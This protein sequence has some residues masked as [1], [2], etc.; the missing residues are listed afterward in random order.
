MKKTSII[1]SLLLIFAC[2]DDKDSTGPEVTINSPANNATLGELVTIKV[3]TTDNSGI[4]KVDFYIDNSKVFSDTTLPYEYEWNTTTTTDSEHT[5]K[6]TS[7][8]MN[9][10]FTETE[11]ITVTVDNDSKRPNP[12]NV[13]SVTYNLQRMT[14]QWDYS[15]D[16]DFKEYI[17]YY[18]E[19]KTGTK[20]LIKTYDNIVNTKYETTDFNPLKEN[21]YFIEV[22][23]KF[24]LKTMGNGKVNSIDQP[25]TPAQLSIDFSDSQFKVSWI[26]QEQ[27]DHTLYELVES[28]TEDMANPKVIFSSQTNS[29]NEYIVTGI[30]ENERK[31]YR[32]DITDYWGLISKSELAVGSTFKKIAFIAN[33]KDGDPS[34]I[35]LSDLDGKYHRAITSSGAYRKIQFHPDGAR[36]LSEGNNGIQSIDIDDGSIHNIA[37]GGSYSLSSD[38]LLIAYKHKDNCL[39]IVNIDGSNQI[40]YCNN[41]S[42]SEEGGL[43]NAREPLISAE[44]KKIWFTTAYGATNWDL[45]EY[46]ISTGAVNKLANDANAVLS[47]YGESV[48]VY[49]SSINF[50]GAQQLFLSTPNNTT[51][52]SLSDNTSSLPVFSPNDL[53]I[54]YVSSVWPEGSHSIY[55]YDIASNE[56]INLFTSNYR[57]YSLD[58]SPDGMSIVFAI[59]NYI[60]NKYEVYTMNTDGSN[61]QKIIQ[62]KTGNDFFRMEE[63]I[64]QPY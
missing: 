32:F 4:L 44:G 25:P 13:T 20:Q 63:F 61:L 5:I 54:Y 18:S 14:V 46:I 3:N 59:N 52:F 35:Y 48:F 43:Y 30:G 17:L 50:D 29:S 42:S 60:E 8:D 1:L 12:I 7:Y 51:K 47:S 62:S 55:K 58:V 19:S 24:G 11:T 31:F 26:F 45:Y 10:N 36:I 37:N 53:Y 64:F 49:R 40:D 16:S 15:N 33:T 21:W 27:N 9:E 41:Y 6:V 34:Y 56:N 2:E 28:E 39:S 38:G 23:D 57:I 22:V